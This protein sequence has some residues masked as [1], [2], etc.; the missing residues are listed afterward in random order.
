MF[1][2]DSKYVMG[3]LYLYIKWT[4]SF[5][6]IHVETTILLIFSSFSHV[7]HS[8]SIYMKKNVE[9]KCLDY[10]VFTF[11]MYCG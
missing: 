11:Q 9:I 3:R 10:F 6:K 7:K 1:K 4:N 8:I 2:N 5:S